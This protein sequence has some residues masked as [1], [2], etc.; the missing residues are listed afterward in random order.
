MSTPTL[1]AAELDVLRR[2]NTPTISNAIEL[3][4]VRPRHEGFLPHTIRCLLPDLGPIVG[5]AV[6]SRTR[7]SKPD[8][9]ETQ[10]D[11]LGD[12]LRYVAS[13]PGPKIAVGWDL[14]E[15]PGLGAQFGE[16]T[17][18]IHQKLGCVGHITSGCPRDLDE[19][20][21]LGFQ[22]FGLN[23]C[24][25]H[26][27]VRLV[28]FGSP[29]VIGGVEIRSGELIHADKH[30]ICLIPHEV[31]TRLAQACIEVESRERPLL[32]MCRSEMFS[33]EE[34]I[35]LRAVSHVKTGE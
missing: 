29:V 5:Y 17:A 14:D 20:E 23:P 18:T 13:V 3:F 11:L 4:D 24:V 30:G 26:A 12:Y 2:Y 19:V 16:V 21:A 33:L 28:D 9:G 25:S 22:L 8:L 7:A 10:V 35:K 32:E 31:A 6:T 1:T 15:P 27:Y 34:Y